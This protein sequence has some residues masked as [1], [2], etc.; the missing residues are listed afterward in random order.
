MKQAILFLFSLYTIGFANAQA[1]KK[2]LK[3]VMEIAMPEGDGSNGGSVVFHP[4]SKKYYIPMLGN[5][6]YPFAVFDSK[7]KLLSEKE[8]GNDLRGLWYNPQ[9]KNIE[10]NCYDE[11]GWVKYKLD[12]KGNLTDPEVIL[13]GMKQPENQS[14]GVFNAKENV[15]YFLYSGG[16]SVYNMNGE[17]IKKIE[18]KKSKSDSAI[19]FLDDNQMYNTTSVIYTGI[20][21]AEIG[22]FNVEEKK[23]ELYNIA[24]GIYTT[25][26]KLP[27][28]CTNYPQFNFAYANNMVWLFDKENRRWVTYK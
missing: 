28:Q 21:K 15:V 24:T 11:G 17:E 8:A 1:Q 4:V 27:E 5:A 13:E 2:S 14:V 26:W 23:I 19:L 6:I 9:T 16:V 22:I 12:A 10:G 7:G 20:A 25:E 3:K 18:L